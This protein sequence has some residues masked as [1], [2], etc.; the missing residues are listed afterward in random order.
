MCVFLN[1]EKVT[2]SILITFYNQDSFIE[3][4]IN[5]CL[6]AFRTSVYSYRILVCLQNPSSKAKEILEKFSRELE[7]LSYIINEPDESLIPLSKAAVNRYKL[8][9][10]ANSKYCMFLD[11]DDAYIDNVDNG[12]DTLEQNS[13]LVG[14]AYSFSLYDW[15]QNSLQKIKADYEDGE[16]ITF[17]S[18]K[19]YVFSNCI[20]F[21]RDALFKKIHPIYCNDT[22][23]TRV[24]LYSGNGVRFFDREI[25]LYS[26]GI[27]SIY[28]GASLAEKVLS[29]FIVNE[30]NI[31]FF[32]E[33]KKIFL[34][35]LKHL[36]KQVNL[37]C[38]GIGLSSCWRRHI[39]S[40]NLTFSKLLLASVMT[41]SIVVRNYYKLVLKFYIG[42][43]RFLIS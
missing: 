19:R 35:R 32:P 17:E 22:T 43:N 13:N 8:L 20:V 30:E 21:R 37:N 28:K 2:L 1:S 4:A 10:L 42:L 6:N 12:I 41:R 23:I 15:S 33:H 29:E 26:V 3:R 31:K 11:G 14:C 5:S 7:C 27:P 38:N 25:L 34:K 9:T 16:V 36:T 24:L 39:I 40:R 18:Y